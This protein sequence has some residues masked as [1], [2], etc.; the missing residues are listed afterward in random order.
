MS[1]LSDTPTISQMK[2]AWLASCKTVSMQE[3]EKRFDLFVADVRATEIEHIAMWR[4][5]PGGVYTK[6]LHKAREIRRA[7]Q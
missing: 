5:F 6:L 4:E 3:Q 1:K 2:L 7:V